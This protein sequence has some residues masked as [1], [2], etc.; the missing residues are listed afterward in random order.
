MGMAH[1]H[2]PLL[3]MRLSCCV[4]SSFTTEIT[5]VTTAV[6][7]YIYDSADWTHTRP[8]SEGKVGGGVWE[9]TT[10]GQEFH[11]EGV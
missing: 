8:P 6:V 5:A 1:E 3:G 4:C 11:L 7:I 10:R 9:L 2:R